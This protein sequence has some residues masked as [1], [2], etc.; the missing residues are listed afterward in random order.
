MSDPVESRPATQRLAYIFPGQ[1]SQSVGMGKQLAKEFDVAQDTFHEADE[2]LG[3]SLS[4]LA[5]EGPEGQLNDTINTQPALFI[6]SIAA[7]R[8]LKEAMPGIVPVL[9]AGHS[10][11]ELSAL[12]AAG[13]LTFQDGLRLVR[14]RGE[15]MKRAGELSP[16]GMAAILSLDIDVVEKLCEES[17]TPEAVV[18]VANDNCP[19]QIV[20]S[21][22]SSALELAMQKAK[23]AGARRVVPLAVSIA[24]H[25]PLMAHAQ[26]QF[27]QAVD[28][29][30]ML[31]PWIP[32]VGN[33]NARPLKT[34]SEIRL[35]LQAQL[36]S[37]VRWTESVQYMTST[38]V[39]TFLEIG[40]NSVLSGLVKRISQEAKGFPLGNP[41]DFHKLLADLPA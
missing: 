34:T 33:V 9:V 40:S 16:G 12:V 17:S 5:W 7:L 22:S 39:N 21:G 20:I 31:D 13:T 8:V 35:D 26:E 19:G 1:G 41:E 24:A 37:R 10:M 4:Q 29:T 36:S 6:H 27:N 28:T 2:L 25:S 38:G 14:T 32:I 11:G 30:H 3:Y 18:Q 23:D 15:L